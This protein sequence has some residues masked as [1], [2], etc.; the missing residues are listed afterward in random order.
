MTGMGSDGAEGLQEMKFAGARAIALD[1]QACVVC[2]MPRHASA[3][4]AANQIVAHDEIAAA[5][6]GKIDRRS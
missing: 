5:V 4:G 1:D 6:L 2:G 3:I